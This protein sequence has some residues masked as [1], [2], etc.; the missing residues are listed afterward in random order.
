MRG[1]DVL[2]G[3]AHFRPVL[4][5]EGDLTNEHLRVERCHE[6]VE[7]ASG[8]LVAEQDLH[9]G[10]DIPKERGEGAPRLRHGRVPNQDAESVR[11]LLDVSQE[12]ES[13][14]LDQVH[15]YEPGVLVTV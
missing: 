7:P 15:V 8:K 9:L 4:A 5:S 1:N 2:G 11:R 3:L 10:R 14:P 6:W 13:G 12:R